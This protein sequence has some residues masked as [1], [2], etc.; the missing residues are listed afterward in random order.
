MGHQPIFS[1][2]AAAKDS[3]TLLLEAMLEQTDDQWL[4]VNQIKHGTK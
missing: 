4:K 1:A 2:A 3:A